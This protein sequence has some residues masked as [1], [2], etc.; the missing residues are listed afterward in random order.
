MCHK[1]CLYAF[2]GY[3]FQLEE[4]KITLERMNQE[5]QKSRLANTSQILHFQEKLEHAQ[6]Q[7]E[8]QEQSFVVSKGEKRAKVSIK[9]HILLEESRISV[10]Y[11]VIRSLIP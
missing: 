7:N 2:F 3:F 10:E 4:C 8:Q 11:K 1:C 5:H 6:D 9:E